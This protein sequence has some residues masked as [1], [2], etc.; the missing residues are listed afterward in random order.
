[1]D[2]AGVKAMR[3]LSGLHPFVE[4][5][6]GLQDKKRNSRPNSQYLSAEHHRGEMRRVT[7]WARL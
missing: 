1:M 4:N 6:G 7:L 3:N 2:K 5:H